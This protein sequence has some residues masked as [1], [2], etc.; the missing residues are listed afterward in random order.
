MFKKI[1]IANRGEIALRV[2]RACR[3]L[4]IKTVAIHSEADESAM[5]VRMADESICVGPASAQSSY[6][7][8]PAIITAATLTNADGIHPGY[9]FLSENQRFAEIIE[10][11]N[12]K[13]IGPHS[14]HIKIMGNKIDAKRVMDENNVPTVPGLNDISDIKKIEQFIKSFDFPIIVKAAS[15]GGGKGMRVVTKYDEINN[16]INSSKA[17]AK[18]SFNDDTVYLEKFL[19]KPKHIEIQILADSHGNVITLGERDCSIQ[20]KHQKLIEESPSE[21]LTKEKRGEISDLCKKAV[22]S[23]GYEGVGTLEFLYENDNFYFMEMNTRLQVE[24]PV[25]EMVTGIDL[26]KQQILSA[27]GEKLKISQSDIQLKGHSIECRINAEH[28]QSFIPSP[29]KITQYHQPGGLGVRVDSAVYQGYSVPTH[30]DS[31]IGKLITYADN[32]EECIVR[33][34][35]ALEEYVIMGINTNI[36]L[37]QKI[38]MSEEFKSGKYNINF[39]STFN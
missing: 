35:R 26:V 14:N 22:S 2:L 29:G 15:G 18:K 23:I 1:L 7:N 19:T 10:E 37:H 25:T 28:P 30:Y 31:M 4:G 27:S 38:I 13:F 33:M 36:Q 39:M 17:E 34:N 16:A 24:H 11:H 9:G 21:L 6:L 32:R 12:I 3:E 8:I 5:H 20:R